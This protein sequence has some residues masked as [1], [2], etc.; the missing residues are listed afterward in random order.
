MK[1]TIKAKDKKHLLKLITKEIEA[2]GNECNLN[3]IDVSQITDMSGLFNEKYFNGDISKWDVS[4]VEDMFGMFMGSKF[5]GDI[6]NWNTSKVKNMLYLFQSSNFNG[7][8]SN[9]NVSSVITMHAMFYNSAFSQ[10]INNW[11][12][13]SLSSFEDS[14]EDESCLLCS[15]II[16]P[17]WTQFDNQKARNKAIDAYNLSKSLNKELNIGQSDLKN[18]KL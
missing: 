6:S 2:N 13:Y 9:W 15:E 11:K 16:N 1:R 4:N 14:F 5:N 12:P 18:L 3:H 8:I 17:Y 7:D 10:D